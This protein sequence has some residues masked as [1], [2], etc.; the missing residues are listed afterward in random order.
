VLESAPD[1]G[2]PTL[3]DPLDPQR[4]SIDGH[5]IITTAYFDRRREHVAERL[6]G[7]LIHTTSF[8]SGVHTYLK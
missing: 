6:E 5:Q 7:P 1:I 4:P 8:D 2:Q 3:T